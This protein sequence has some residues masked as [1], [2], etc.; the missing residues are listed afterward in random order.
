MIQKTIHQSLSKHQRAVYSDMNKR[1]NIHLLFFSSLSGT[2]SPQTKPN[3]IDGE[4]STRISSSNSRSADKRDKTVDNHSPLFASRMG[5][6]FL[7]ITLQ[8]P[9]STHS[10]GNCNM[11][12]MFLDRVYLFLCYSIPPINI[13]DAVTSNGQEVIKY[14]PLIILIINSTNKLWFGGLLPH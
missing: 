5:Q 14:N 4:P 3:V 2:H 10:L 11:G 13:Q 6:G 9:G 8:S 1:V 12:G 7:A